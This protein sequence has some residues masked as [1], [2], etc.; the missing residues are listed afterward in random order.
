MKNPAGFVALAVIV[1]M[2]GY[3]ALSTDQVWM[4]LGAAI[5]A[6]LAVASVLRNQRHG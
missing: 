2:L 4:R 3:F 5:G 6:V 1:L